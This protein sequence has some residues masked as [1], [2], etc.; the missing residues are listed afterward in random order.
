VRLEGGKGTITFSC[1]EA[2][3]RVLQGFK[4]SRIGEWDVILRPFANYQNN[5]TAFMANV[6]PA[7]NEIT[8]QQALRDY[9]PIISCKLHTSNS[10]I[11]NATV[12]FATEYPPAY[13]ER[14]SNASSQSTR[15]TRPSGSPSPP[16]PTSP[17]T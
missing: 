13:P 4:G 16:P 8:F 15:P 6:N 7:L 5:Y 12:T 14:P 10:R 9:E 1:A 3:D 17:S 11:I 2:A